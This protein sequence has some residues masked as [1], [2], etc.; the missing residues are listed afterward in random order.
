MYILLYYVRLVRLNPISVKAFPA[1][2][3]RWH[4][5]MILY[6]T[7]IAGRCP[8]LLRFLENEIFTTI[9]PD[10]DLLVHTFS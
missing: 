3:L 2:S 9:L 5:N 10:A 4:V 1:I 8:I 6:Y 7:Y